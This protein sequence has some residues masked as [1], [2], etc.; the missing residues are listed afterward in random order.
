M[1]AVLGLPEIQAR[2]FRVNLIPHGA[3]VPNDGIACLTCHTDFGGSPRNA[4]GMDVEQLVTPGSPEPF[5]GPELAMLDSDGDGFTNG[6]ELQD[7][8]GTWTPGSPQ[9]GDAA[10]V[11]HPGD[12]NSR[13]AQEPTTGDAWVAYLT[14][15]EGIQSNGYGIVVFQLNEQEMT[16][17]YYVNVFGLENITNSHIHTNVT[18]G[19][20][21]PIEVPTDGSSSGSI[22]ITQE[23][24]DNMRNGI[25]YVN[26]HTGKSREKPVEPLWMSPKFRATYT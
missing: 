21:H 3:D 14:A 8:E 17:D 1:L 16:L 12:P 4:F 13:P 20:V 22:T 25:Y 24:L 23:D 26:V 18:G 5:W 7:P 2:D 11:T 15:V 6:Q 9:P 10:L 19:V